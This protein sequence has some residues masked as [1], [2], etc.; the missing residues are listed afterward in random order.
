AF[1]TLTF[2]AASG[3]DAAFAVVVL[4][5]DNYTGVGTGRGKKIVLSGGPTFILWPGQTLFIFNSNNVWVAVR[6]SLWAIPQN[7]TFFGA[8]SGGDDTFD[9][10]AAA[11]PWATFT[12]AK[13]VF[14]KQLDFAGQNVLFQLADG[15]YGS[16]FKLPLWSGGGS[17]DLQGNLSTPT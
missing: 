6:R 15:T 12:N 13:S 11:S 9:G 8:A 7:A 3:Y 1:F 16:Q 5:E 14:E 17:F 4:N 10:L 2:G